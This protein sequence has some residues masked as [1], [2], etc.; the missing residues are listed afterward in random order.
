MRT[1]LRP[2][3]GNRCRYCTLVCFCYNFWFL[4][5]C[6]Y[7]HR[8]LCKLRC[9]FEGIQPLHNTP[10][11]C[12]IHHSEIF[13]PST[14]RNTACPSLCQV[15]PNHWNLQSQAF[16]PKKY[17]VTLALSQQKGR[18]HESIKAGSTRTEAMTQNNKQLFDSSRLFRW[19]CICFPKE[20]SQPVAEKRTTKSMVP[21]VHVP[22]WCL[23]P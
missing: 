1:W 7:S 18:E 19:G 6:L 17:S 20:W 8:K 4:S 16:N 22:R 14:I 3:P 9:F 15:S 5:S 11:C 12:K 23:A 21:A 10:T 2:G 13:D